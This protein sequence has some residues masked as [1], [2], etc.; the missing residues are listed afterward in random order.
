VN[1]PSEPGRERSSSVTIIEST[2]TPTE[3][4][5][6]R[7]RASLTATSAAV[8]LVVVA[9]F[10]LA[11]CDDDTT[12][13]ATDQT[14]VATDAADITATGTAA[15][16][17]RGFVEAYG[18]FDAERAISYLADDADI[19]GLFRSYTAEGDVDQIPLILAYL[20]VLDTQLMLR[21]CEELTSSATGTSVRCGY[22]YHYMGSDEL[23]LGPYDGS[24]FDLTVRDGEIV[25]AIGHPE[26][27]TSSY[28]TWAPF[29][30]WIS[31]NYPADAEVMY[32]DP[33]HSSARLTEESFRLW[34]RRI[35][36]WVDSRLATQ[37]G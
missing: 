11:A 30:V 27:S 18:A 8:A 21:S 14:P 7:R 15:E 16:V 35:H 37:D 28:Q 2:T 34:D 24:Y 4:P 22:D 32:N 10:G 13:P 29:D 3:P 5:S 1:P 36:E 20:E 33:T 6:G 31:A 26:I 19:T 25:Q 17:A 12:E 23:G 9:A